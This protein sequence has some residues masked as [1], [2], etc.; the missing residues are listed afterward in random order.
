MKTTEAE[1]RSFLATLTSGSLLGPLARDFIRDL[2]SDLE[3]A[4]ALAKDNGERAERAE[5]FSV[6]VKTD[7]RIALADVEKAE[8]VAAQQAEANVALRAEV[9]QAK[10]RAERAEKLFAEWAKGSETMRL[11]AEVERKDAAL[12]QAR[13]ALKR[14][15]LNTCLGLI[16]AALAPAP[17]GGGT[18]EPERASREKAGV[19]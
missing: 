10:E 3:V 1:R 12:R 16:D 15:H 18:S 11:R 19:K 4:L 5:E 2:F 17:S 8:R 13:N 6:H 14:D 7:L 9:A